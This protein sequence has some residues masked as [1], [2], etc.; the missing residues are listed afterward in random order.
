MHYYYH[1]YC[2]SPYWIMI[3]S[4]LCVVGQGFRSEKSMAT[5]QGTEQKWRYLPQNMALNGTVLSLYIYIYI[6]TL[7]Y[8]PWGKLT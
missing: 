8:K 6:H 2:F 3:G 1:S 5:Q 7:L 4:L